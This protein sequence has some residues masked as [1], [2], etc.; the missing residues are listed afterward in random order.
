MTRIAHA[1]VDSALE[2]AR[3]RTKNKDP[4]GAVM[5]FFTEVLTEL[6]RAR[7]YHILLEI[8]KKLI[9]SIMEKLE[10][11]QLREGVNKT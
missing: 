1:H 11:K 5:L 8:Q 7:V 9:V 4:R 3:F 10:S 6:L 2:K